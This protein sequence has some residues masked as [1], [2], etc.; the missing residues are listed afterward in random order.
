MSRKTTSGLGPMS[1]LLRLDEELELGLVV[2]EALYTSTASRPLVAER[3]GC[4][5]LS[6]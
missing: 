5:F 4:L 2:A 1:I 3:R 6:A